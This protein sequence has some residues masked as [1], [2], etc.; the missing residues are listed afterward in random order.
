VS[1]RY[2][3]RR[4]ETL[5]RD[6]LKAAQF[7]RLKSVLERA[8]HQS[9]FYR[10]LFDDARVHPDQIK[11]WDDFHGR[12]PFIDKRA[13]LADQAEAPPWGRKLTVPPD[14]IRKVY[15]TSGTS[16][17]GQEVHPMTGTDFGAAAEIGFFCFTWA[18]I[19]PGDRNALFWPLATMAG[20]QAAYG[21]LER[22][23]ANVMA[24]GIF[25]SNT[26]IRR[27]IDFSHQYV[28][29]TPVY[30]TRLTL[31]CREMGVE[32]ATALPGLKGIILSTG[33]F[34]IEWAEEMEQFWGTR[35][36]DCYGSTQIRA[37][38]ASTCE[39]G[40]VHDGRRGS[41]HPAEPFVLVEIVDPATGALVE[42]GDEGEPV[43]TTLYQDA[44]PMIR[45]RQGDKIRRLPPDACDCGRTGEVWEAGTIARY[46]D[47]LKIRGQNVWPLAVDEAVFAYREIEEYSGRVYVAPGGTEE[48]V[49]SVEFRKETPAPDRPRILAGLPEQLRQRT[50]I[51]MAVAE[52]AYGT[53][54]RFEYKAVRWADERQ[55]GLT[56]VTFTEK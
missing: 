49:L 44:A 11:S 38:Y 34:P 18:G 1:R 42:Y 9:L 20:G 3:D 41:Y 17:V 23:G 28:W 36:Y 53:I 13:L 33:A 26:K 31:L 6:E 2:H 4:L 56:K 5:P 24:L 25:D 32:P 45:F 30:L 14:Q 7:A 39:K 19:E 40:V 8:Y 29:A 16:G 43:V 52:V 15:I 50:G 12:I 51:R 37:I 47:M 27:L 46:D 21:G 35:L 54:P 55:A 48:V 22:F 10:R